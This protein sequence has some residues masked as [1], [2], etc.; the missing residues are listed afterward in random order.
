MAIYLEDCRS[1]RATLQQQQCYLHWFLR[2]PITFL[3]FEPWKRLWH[4]QAWN[5][6][7][8]IEKWKDAFIGNP[9]WNHC[10]LP[11][12]RDESKL[13]TLG[14]DL[15]VLRQWLQRWR[16]CYYQKNKWHASGLQ[17]I[18]CNPLLILLFLFWLSQWMESPL[19]F[20][21]CGLSLKGVLDFIW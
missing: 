19:E 18:R 12:I 1:G 16:S 3:E 6:P 5:L 10:V 9:L 4:R 15:E 2:Q 13:S 17:I 11:Y 20:T 7:F 8:D 21:Y 14:S